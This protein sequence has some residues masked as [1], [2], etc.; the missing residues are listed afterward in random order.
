MGSLA[1]TTPALFLAVA[2]AALFATGL[3][4]SGTGEDHLPDLEELDLPRGDI[5]FD[6]AAMYTA[7][8]SKLFFVEPE[9]WGGAYVDGRTLHVNA[10]GISVEEATR[11]I[12]DLGFTTGFEV[13]ET[14]TSLE[15]FGRATEAI[16]DDMATSGTVGSVGQDYSQ[17]RIVMGLDGAESTV[18]IDDAIDRFEAATTDL[19]EAGID[20]ASYDGGRP[21]TTASRSY[22]TSPF[23][24][25]AA[26]EFTRRGHASPAL[27]CTTAFS[28]GKDSHQYLVTAAH[29]T[30]STSGESYA[31]AR[32]IAS[33]ESVHYYGAVTW[34]SGGALRTG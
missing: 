33:N 26:V 32:R 3:A 30:M 13:L 17:E 6:P 19:R 5:T 20:V 23:K 12:S 21:E 9:L 22:D 14:S 29:C 25:G 31:N 11:R 7:I 15:D 18:A 16:A 10:V 27:P 4:P 28:W 2:L 34:R 24:G 1:P 8:E